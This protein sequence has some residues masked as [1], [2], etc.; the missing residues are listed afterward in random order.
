MREKIRKKIESESDIR[1]FCKKNNIREA[2]VYDFLNNKIN[3]TVRNV[4]EIMKALDLEVA[5]KL[6]NKFFEVK[7]IL[8]EG[9]TYHKGDKFEGKTIVLCFG[10]NGTSYQSLLLRTNIG[11][12][13]KVI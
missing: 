4:E 5:E 6:P 12:H 10:S 8:Y 11:M 9:S 2:T 3:T 13:L 1:E 7:S